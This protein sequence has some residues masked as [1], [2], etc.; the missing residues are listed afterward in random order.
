[1]KVYLDASV[2]VPIFVD[3]DWTAQVDAWLTTKPAVLVSDWT[4]AEFSS[5]LSLHV[6]RGRLTP[7]E[8]DD[9]ENALNDWVERLIEV[10]PVLDEDVVHA[11]FALHRHPKLRTP[12]ALH[13]AM[14]LR[15]GHAFASYDEDLVEAARRDGIEVVTP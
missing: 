14:V 8:R 13:L 3:D 2:L 15:L 1:M 12:D 9:A 5:A 7:E 4:L 10:A 6:R 11:R